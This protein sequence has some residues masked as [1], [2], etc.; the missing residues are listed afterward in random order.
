[1]VSSISIAMMTKNVN[2]R[3]GLIG[4]EFAYIYIL[5]II[6]VVI[7]FLPLKGIYFI[8]KR[9]KIFCFYFFF[10]LFLFLYCIL[11]IVHILYYHVVCFCSCYFVEPVIRARKKKMCRK[12]K[13]F[14]FHHR[15]SIP[16]RFTRNNTTV[17]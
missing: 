11:Y 15:S 4:V 5:I 6:Y 9:S 12:R 3:M 8:I 16:T 2:K 13:S 14:T 1:M 10:L 17:K 7:L